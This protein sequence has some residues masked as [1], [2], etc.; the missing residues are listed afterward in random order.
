MNGPVM[1]NTFE[2]I[3]RKQEKL[4]NGLIYKK[5]QTNYSLT[6]S[7]SAYTT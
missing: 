7:V 2:E 6:K 1:V 4:F 5:V 3:A